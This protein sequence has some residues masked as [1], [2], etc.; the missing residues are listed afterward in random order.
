MSR[1]NVVE[2]SVQKMYL[3][4]SSFAKA[5]MNHSCEL[6]LRWFCRLTSSEIRVAAPAVLPGAA[7]RA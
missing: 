5:S 7:R 6:C 4:W 1:S 2:Q 3:A